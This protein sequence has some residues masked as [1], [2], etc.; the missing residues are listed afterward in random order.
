LYGAT[1]EGGTGGNGTIFQLTPPKGQGAWAK[2]VLYNFPKNF[3][4]S[5]NSLVI[6]QAG[7]L[8]GTTF[9]GGQYSSGIVFEMSPPAPQGGAW[10]FTVLHSFHDNFVDGSN[11]AGLG[12]GANGWLY[13][14]TNAG[15]TND[16]GTV[17][18]LHPATQGNAWVESVLYDFSGFVDPVGN[19]VFDSQGNL[20]GATS[21]GGGYSCDNFE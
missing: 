16:A 9:Y 8:Y 3:R 21:F 11:P 17:F 13:G 12:I 4:A 6:D 15:G 14:L 1:S 19:P 5:V 2:T 18:Q 7:N 20:Y 10:S